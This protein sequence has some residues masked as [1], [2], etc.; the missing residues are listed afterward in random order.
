MRYF[1]FLSLIF[2]LLLISAPAIWAQPE[3]AFY[4]D[5]MVYRT[6][7]TPAH[8]PDHGPK[9]GLFVFQGLDGQMP[10]AEAKPGDRD[11]NGGRWQVYFVSFTESGMD[12]HDPDG[13]GMVNFQLTSWE[14]VYEHIG[15]GHLEISG[16]G[17][18]FVCP[19]IK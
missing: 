12:A 2:L 8:L 18:S 3:S 7:A 13:D 5:G 1:V 4:V 9:D 11:Y 17:P 15:L 16:M 14:A 19:V 6:I 10:I